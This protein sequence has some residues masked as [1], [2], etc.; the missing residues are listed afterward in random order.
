MAQQAAIGLT[1]H[2]L[3]QVSES[4][5]ER[6]AATDEPSAPEVEPIVIKE[7]LKPECPLCLECMETIVCGPCG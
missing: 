1:S 3:E 6:A 2:P 5:A 4:S 7:R